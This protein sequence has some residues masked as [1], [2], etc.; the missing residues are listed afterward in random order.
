MAN[1][2][3]IETL[4]VSLDIF[5]IE[6]ADGAPPMTTTYMHV[7][8]RQDGA[9]EKAVMGLPAYRGERGPAGPPGAIHQGGRTTDQLDALATVLSAQN[10][11]WTYRNTDDESQYV[12][13]GETFIIYPDVYSHPG[14][15]GPAP[16]MTP[17]T[18]TIDGEEYSGPYGVRVAGSEGSYSVGLDLPELPKGEQGPQG[19]AGPIYTSVDVDQSSNRVDGSTLVY[20]ESSGK[21]EWAKTVLGTEEYGIGPS[22]FDVAASI[23]S[24]T[25]RRE[26]AA[27]EI[28][29]K[30]YAYRLDFAGGIDVN[31]PF[32]Y[33]I[34]VEI[35][36]DDPV[37]GELVGLAR[38]DSSQGWHRLVFQPYCD[39]SFEPG[40]STGVIPVGTATQLYVS[41][42][43]KQG[44]VLSWGLRNDLAHLRIRLIRVP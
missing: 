34:D 21:L 31:E 29:A 30:D 3:P 22:D 7:R 36:K 5:G 41:A 24:G 8:R 35:R 4:G 23:P 6:Q 9:A 12:W 17:G 33:H 16:T 20:N 40:Q 39:S 18:L 38:S 37:T 28:P 14:P 25:S 2:D 32:G 44:S 13:S 26:L 10:T 1:E 11:N 42:V 43:R 19:P 27:L 15:V